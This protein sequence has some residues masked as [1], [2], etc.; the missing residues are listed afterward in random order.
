MSFHLCLCNQ[1]QA[2]YLRFK[3]LK[4]IRNTKIKYF[5]SKK[6]SQK[7]FSSNSFFHEQICLPKKILT[8]EENYERK[9]FKGDKILKLKLWQ[10]KNSNSD[11]T[12]KLKLLDKKNCD[13]THYGKSK[14]KKEKKKKEKSSTFCG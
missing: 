4:K 2:P 12:H 11:I 13:K 1:N 8:K 6:I 5:T 14:K 7:L 10:L 9:N 3:N